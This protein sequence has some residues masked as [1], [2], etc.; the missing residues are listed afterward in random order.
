MKWKTGRPDKD[1]HYLATLHLGKVREI[2]FTVAGGW[3]THIDSDGN[4]YKEYALDDSEV[5]GWINLP[6]PM[7]E[8]FEVV[9]SE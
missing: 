6:Q 1:G 2:T 9:W 7:P 5:F 3:N 4:V 8:S